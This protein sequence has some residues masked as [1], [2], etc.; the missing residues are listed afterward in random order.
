MKALFSIT[1]AEIWNS[2][3]SPKFIIVYMAVMVLLMGLIVVAAMINERRFGKLNGSLKQSAA[4]AEKQ[5]ETVVRR[6]ETLCQIDDRGGGI[7]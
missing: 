6:F 5:S 1:L 2:I 4:K 7:H 3:K